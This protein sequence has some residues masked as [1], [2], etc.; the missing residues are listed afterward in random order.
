MTEYDLVIVGAGIPPSLIQKD[1][2]TKLIY[3]IRPFGLIAAHTWLSLCPDSNVLLLESGPD[4]GCVL[5]QCCYTSTDPLQRRLVQL[6]YLS[7]ND[8]P[9][10]ARNV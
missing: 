2:H 4:L 9:N 6:P 1:S 5:F 3:F 10:T 7:N 8:D